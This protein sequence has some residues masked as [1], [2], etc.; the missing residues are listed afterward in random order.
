[1]RATATRCRRSSPRNGR[2]P[3]RCC[4]TTSASPSTSCRAGARR[5]PAR[6]SRCP[7]MAR[8]LESIAATHGNAFYRGELAQAMVAHAQGERRAAHARRFRRAHGRLG[9]RRSRSTI[10]ATTVHEIPPNGQGIAALMALGILR[11][12]DLAVAAAGLRREPAPADRG[13]E[14]RLRR[15]LSLRQRS[16]HDGGRAVGAARPR[17]PR[18]ARAPDRSE[19]RAGFR[20]GRAAARRHRLPLRRRRA[21]HDGVADPVE[22]HGLRL[23]RRRARHR[24]QPAESRRRLFARSPATRTRSAAASGRSTRSFP[25]SSRATA[26][27]SPPSA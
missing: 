10:A 18:V 9:R 23:G 8:T 22:L 4:R 13:D 17:L 21:R 6:C 2:W 25:A 14:A 11:A 7:A 1:M 19:A 20:P 3:R 5:P 16:A 24:H 12:F 27:R 15:R 26:R